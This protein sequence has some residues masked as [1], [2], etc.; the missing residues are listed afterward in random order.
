M[1][2]L[3]SK[4]ILKIVRDRSDSLDYV[5]EKFKGIDYK[6]LLKLLLEHNVFLTLY[7]R[8]ISFIPE[9]ILLNG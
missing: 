9:E 8:I 1:L 2:D 6:K 7:N 4:M 3:E 5:F